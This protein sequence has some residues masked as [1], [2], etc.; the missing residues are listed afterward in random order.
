MKKQRV[1]FVPIYVIIR[2]FLYKFKE[3][4]IIILTLIGFVRLMAMDPLT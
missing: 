3:K 4:L 1:E 2:S